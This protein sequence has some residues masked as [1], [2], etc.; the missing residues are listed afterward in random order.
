MPG[1]LITTS[2]K[3]SQRTRSFI[4]DLANT[5]PFSK[6]VNRGKKTIEE[7]G[8]EAYRDKKQYIFIVGERK[9]NP[10]IIKIYRV[11]LDEKPP[12]TK[13]VATIIIKG[14]N[15]TRENPDA[16]RAYN[17]ET[18][19]IDYNACIKDECYKLADIL[20][21]IFHET[22]SDKADVIIKLEEI[23]KFIII[24][25]LNRLGK[26]CGPIIRVIG[27]KIHV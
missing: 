15:L 18:I 12:K 21:K 10:S 7:L 2:H 23:K 19:T 1:V 27:V 3:P 26:P 5:L 24:K 13:H 25:P 6:H 8:L 11:Y 22:I 9:G 14:V 17:P 4:K 16:S 20:I